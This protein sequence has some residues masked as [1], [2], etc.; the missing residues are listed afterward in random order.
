MITFNL[1][2]RP[3]LANL[4]AG[5][6]LNKILNPFSILF[7][8]CNIYACEFDMHLFQS[9][10]L[11]IDMLLPSIILYS[12]AHPMSR[13]LY[14][15]MLGVPVPLLAHLSGF[16]HHNISTSLCEI[17]FILFYCLQCRNFNKKIKNYLTPRLFCVDQRLSE[18]FAYFF[19]QS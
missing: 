11:C 17:L 9:K 5:H 7:P 10:E 12:T 4:P 16:I 2:C 13:I 8:Q 3:V 15:W 18:R 14:L 1:A 19:H 6:Q